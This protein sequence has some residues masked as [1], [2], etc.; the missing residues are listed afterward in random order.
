MR[1]ALGMM[2]G[3]VACSMASQAQAQSYP[4]K[5]VRIIASYAPGGATDVLGRLVATD[6][7]KPLGGSVVVENRPGAGGRIGTRACKSAAPDGYTLCMVSPA[8]AIAPTLFKDAGYE[9]NDF[10]YVTQLAKVP[11]LLLVHPSLPVNSVSDLIALARK[12]PGELSYASSGGGASAQLAMELLKQQANINIELIT[13]K[14]TGAA[15]VDQVAGRVETAFNAA[16][17]VVAFVNNGK[18]RA[19]AVST[20]DRFPMFPK[21]PTLDE[22]GVKGFEGSSWQ[23]IAAPA[24]VPDP[25]VMRLNREIV[26][27]L[28]T[29]AMREKILDLGGVVVASGPAEFDAFFKAEAKKWSGVATKAGL[30]KN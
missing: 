25:I 27:I 28:R 30:L 11:N 1:I 22:S 21:V 7:A 23:G 13:Y 15:I 20:L 5:P 14:G 18:L 8:Q 12:H 17:G 29:A 16:V 19:V 2:L 4:S 26:T 24:G 3:F 9:L 6:L 10:S